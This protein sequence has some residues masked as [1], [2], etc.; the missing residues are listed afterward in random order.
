MHPVGTSKRVEGDQ[1]MV[2]AIKRASIAGKK[3]RKREVAAKDAVLNFDSDS[4]GM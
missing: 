1:A 3:K 2:A 4:D